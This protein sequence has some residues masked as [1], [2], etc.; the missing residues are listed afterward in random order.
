MDWARKR[1]TSENETVELRQV[2]EF[3]EFSDEVRKV[4]EAS[5]LAPTQR[6]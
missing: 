5:G 3:E 4:V 1:P 2:Q 6:T